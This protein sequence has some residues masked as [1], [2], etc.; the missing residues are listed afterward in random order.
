MSKLKYF[1]KNASTSPLSGRFY[2]FKIFIELK[3]QMMKLFKTELNSMNRMCE[4]R[5]KR[6][7]KKKTEIH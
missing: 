6:Q 5:G 7:L 1:K 2:K 4:R 3:I